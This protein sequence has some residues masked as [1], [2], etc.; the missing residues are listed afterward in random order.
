VFIAKELEDRF[1]QV[2]ILKKLEYCGTDRAR[3]SG[4]QPSSM[5]TTS[6]DVAFINNGRTILDSKQLNEVMDLV[7][8][9][10]ALK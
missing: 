1:L 3:Q 9:A 6:G 7:Q 10:A 4:S 8:V 2:L 5:D